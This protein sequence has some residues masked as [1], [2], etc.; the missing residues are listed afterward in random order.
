MERKDQNE[1]DR[2]DA[3]AATYHDG[4]RTSS[5]RFSERGH[6]LKAR[7]VSFPVGYRT[8]KEVNQTYELVKGDIVAENQRESFVSFR[9]TNSACKGAKTYTMESICWKRRVVLSAN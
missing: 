6:V 2:K 3:G 4:S 5:D 8:M 7:R 1:P 9:R